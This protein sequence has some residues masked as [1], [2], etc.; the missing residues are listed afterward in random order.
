MPYRIEFT[1][2]AARAFGKL[3]GGIRARLTAKIDALARQPRPHGVE[4]LAGAA[5]RYRV[6]A[7]DYRVVYTIDDEARVVTVAVIGHRSSV[8]R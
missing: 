8:Y 7:G 3:Q 4:K 2:S 6:R 1:S 5:G